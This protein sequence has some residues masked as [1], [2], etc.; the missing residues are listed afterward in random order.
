MDVGEK[1]LLGMKHIAKTRDPAN[2][3]LCHRLGYGISMA[4]SSVG[5]SVEWLSQDVTGRMDK[6]GLEDFLR[7]FTTD[8]DKQVMAPL[9]YF[10]K[11]KGATKTTTSTSK[12]V[13]LR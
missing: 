1:E 8:D 3:E 10:N 12:N 6:I 4:V 5:S 11:E 2:S 7:Q 13:R 9:E